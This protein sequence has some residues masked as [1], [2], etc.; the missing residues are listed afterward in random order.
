MGIAKGAAI[1][2]LAAFFGKIRTKLDKLTV[3]MI[4]KERQRLVEEFNR[5]EKPMSQ[6]PN[7]ARPPYSFFSSSVMKEASLMSSSPNVD[8]MEIAR[9]VTRKAEEWNEMSEEQREPFEAEA[10]KDKERYD[11]EM[12]D[13]NTIPHDIELHEFER[14]VLRWAADASY[15][16]PRTLVHGGD[17]LQGLERDL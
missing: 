17:G 2:G 16:R 5:K 7:E 9:G 14:K 13:F 15:S 8:L 11:R 6:P 10:K 1:R 4:E 12:V 3:N